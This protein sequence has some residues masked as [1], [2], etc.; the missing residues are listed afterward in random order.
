MPKIDPTHSIL[1]HTRSNPI[2]AIT[3]RL[4]EKIATTG[5]N[6]ELNPKV[7]LVR[8]NKEFGFQL[9]KL[10]YF[11]RTEHIPF[12]PDGFDIERI[13]GINFDFCP[14]ARDPNIN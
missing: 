6:I 14:K 5:I 4:S 7:R 2:G 10:S 1:T 13:G 8:T 11:T 12:A 3:K 9:S